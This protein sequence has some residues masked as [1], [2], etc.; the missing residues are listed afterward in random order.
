MLFVT[1]PST[2]ILVSTRNKY[3]GI[4]AIDQLNTSITNPSMESVPPT[5]IPELIIKP[6]K[7]VVHKSKYNPRARVAQNDNIVEYLDQSP[8]AMSTLEV[9]QKFSSQK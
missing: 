3:Y 5:L 9:L 4:Q 8:L 7:G 1:K 6:P 2:D